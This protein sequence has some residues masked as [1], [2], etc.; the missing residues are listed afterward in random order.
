MRALLIALG[1]VL[2][3][4][5]IVALYF[6]G[7]YNG[8]VEKDEA[9]TAQWGQVQTQYQ[10]RFDLIPNL[11]E[12]VKGIFEQ[13][14]AVFGAIAEARTRYAGAVANPAST[15]DDRAAAATQVESALA[16]LLVVVENYPDIRSQAN[17][18]Q[19][20]D[21][22]A[23]TENR[24][25]VERGRYNDLVRSLNTSVRRFP[26]NMIAGM[27][28]FDQRAYFEAASGADVAPRVQF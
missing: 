22:L 24:I 3:I 4:G 27:F 26:A 23:G 21:E 12:A 1:V 20:M 14:Q 15:P 18:T 17:V 28:G 5:L 9:I 11:V 13:E 8:F 19:L 7:A 6:R 2:V 16:R 10:R 25:A